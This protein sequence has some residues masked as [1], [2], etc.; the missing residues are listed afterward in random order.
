MINEWKS[1]L[2]AQRFE[3]IDR[4]DFFRS[5]MPVSALIYETPLRVGQREV[6]INTAIEIHDPWV[7]HTYH[8]MHLRGDVTP[9]GIYVNYDETPRWLLKGSVLSIDTK[10]L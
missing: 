8:V 2:K 6:R 5:S 9:E 3:K 1:L 7:E 4:K 10:R